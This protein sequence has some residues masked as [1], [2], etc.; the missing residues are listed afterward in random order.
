MNDS[1]YRITT[2]NEQHRQSFQ[3]LNL[4]SVSVVF[5]LIPKVAINLMDLLLGEFYLSN[6]GKKRKSPQQCN[7][8]GKKEKQI[9]LRR[10]NLHLNYT[11]KS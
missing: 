9:V 5:V 2:M 7:L 10:S 11:R 3:N 6:S 8:R 4:T 1:Q